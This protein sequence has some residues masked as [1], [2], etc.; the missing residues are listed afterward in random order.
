MLWPAG[1]QH[2]WTQTFSIHKL[3]HRVVIQGTALNR[4]TLYHQDRNLSVQIA[5]CPSLFPRR[6]LPWDPLALTGQEVLLCPCSTA[7]LVHLDPLTTCFLLSREPVEAFAV[8]VE[9][10]T[11]PCSLDTSRLKKTYFFC[12]WMFYKL[13]FVS[14]KTFNLIFSYLHNCV[15]VTFYAIITHKLAV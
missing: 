15:L 6:C 5:Y 13:F 4:F 8:A 2:H 3:K 1:P 14:C 12:L 11:L 9:Y 10:P 7:S